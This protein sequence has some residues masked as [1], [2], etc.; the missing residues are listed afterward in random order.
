MS[1]ARYISGGFPPFHVFGSGFIMDIFEQIKEEMKKVY[2]RDSKPIC[3]LFSGGKDSSLVLTLLWDVLLELPEKLRTKTVH[4]MT[5]DTLVEA[6]VMAEYVER[7]LQKIKS[8]AIEQNL[9]IQVHCVQPKMKDRF[10][11]KA[12]GRGTLISTPNTRHRWCTHALKIKPTQEKLKELIASAP[13]QM[14]GDKTILTCWMGVR[15]EESARRKL[16]IERFQLSEQSLWAR[17]SDF[18]EIMCFHPVKFVSSDELWLY[19]LDRWTLPFG[20]T[21]EDLTTQYG[22]GILECG[23]KTETNQGNACGASGSRLGCWICGMTSGNDPMLL[24]YIEE[25]QNYKGLLDWKNLMLAMRNDIRFREVF[26][27]QQ[28]NR[29]L[30]SQINQ[31]QIDLFDT[32]ETTRAMNRFKKYKRASYDSYS[33]GGMTLEGRRILL[34]YLLYIQKRDEQNL[35]E[36]SEVQAILDAW[37]DTDGVSISRSELMPRDFQYD[38]ALVFL[39]N[40]SVNRKETKNPNKVFYIT[41]ELNK[42]EDELYAFIKNR[43]H[44]NQSNFF[45]FPASQEFKEYKVV[46]NKVNFVICKE[47]IDSK[48]AAAELI[49]RWLGWEYGAFTEETKQAAINHLILSALSE[50]FSKKNKKLSNEVVIEPLPL[51]HNSDG[52]LSFAI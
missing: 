27:R 2:L 9:P 42:E 25:G 47:G 13:I 28:Y 17:H 23:M 21:V 4:V 36:E 10:F 7:T 38:G 48:M 50:G 12:L 29:I 31:E 18:A 52:Q 41:V 24:R 16:S 37:E 11:V 26:P 5:S 40:K 35:I 3:I 45:F 19:L 33:P 30:K 51:S 6:P 34:E 20:I 43:Q 15:N 22:E 1:S 8:S 49:Y 44:I 32:D 14:G 46:W 39:P